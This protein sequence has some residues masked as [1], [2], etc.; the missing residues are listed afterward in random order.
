MHV[1]PE[2]SWQM[3]Q[4]E[5]QFLSQAVQIKAIFWAAN[6]NAQQFMSMIIFIDSQW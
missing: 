5:T 4:I 3:D 6:K 1:Q 2:K